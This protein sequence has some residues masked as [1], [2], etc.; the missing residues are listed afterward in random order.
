MIQIDVI[1]LNDMKTVIL[2]KIQI[3]DVG[4]ELIVEQK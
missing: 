3:F 2:L 1:N 4:F